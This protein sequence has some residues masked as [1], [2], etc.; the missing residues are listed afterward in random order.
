V[1]F[2]IS[3]VKMQTLLFNMNELQFYYIIN[4]VLLLVH[5]RCNNLKMKFIYTIASNVSIYALKV[6][7][8]WKYSFID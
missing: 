5:I 4:W 6:E 2:P 8:F 7:K 1:F 3:V